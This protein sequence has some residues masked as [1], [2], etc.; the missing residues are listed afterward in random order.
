MNERDNEH[1]KVVVKFKLRD[2]IDRLK[3][4]Q[5]QLQSKFGDLE[6][7]H[8]LGESVQLEGGLNEKWL[9]INRKLKPP[10]TGPRPGFEAPARPERL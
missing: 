6:E 8:R 4:E 7:F 10:P 3:K 1:E 9:E 5:A 2:T